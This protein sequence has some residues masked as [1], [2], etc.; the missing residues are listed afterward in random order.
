MKG[1]V[2]ERSNSLIGNTSGWESGERKGEAKKENRMHQQKRNM[3]REKKWS[4]TES[5]QQCDWYDF[6]KVSDE[7]KFSVIK[8]LYVLIR[9]L[10]LVSLEQRYFCLQKGTL[11]CQRNAAAPD[12]SLLL[13][14]VLYHGY[15]NKQTRPLPVTGGSPTLF[16]HTSGSPLSRVF[17]LLKDSINLK[18]TEESSKQTPPVFPSLS[19]IQLFSTSVAFGSF[20]PRQLFLLLLFPL[21]FLNAL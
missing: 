20:S 5:M 13:G 19:H 21:H 11:V 16:T 15:E 6:A 14:H 2:N 8:A 9:G 4:T 1:S 12:P 17:A 10:L 3:Q 7:Q 18:W